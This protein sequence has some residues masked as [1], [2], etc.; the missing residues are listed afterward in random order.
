MTILLLTQRHYNRTCMSPADDC[1]AKCD[2][3]HQQQACLSITSPAKLQRSAVCSGRAVLSAHQGLGQEHLQQ[4]LDSRAEQAPQRFRTEMDCAMRMVMTAPIAAD[5]TATNIAV[6]A[7]A[8]GGPRPAQLGHE[9]HSKAFEPSKY[10]VVVSVVV[11]SSTS[12]ADCADSAADGAAVG[13]CAG[14]SRVAEALCE[15]LPAQFPTTTAAKRAL[16]RGRVS[17]N[18]RLAE[19]HMCACV[20]T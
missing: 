8:N 18:G 11:P 5:C 9:A 16:R 2:M 13:G 15:L 7:P 1:R 12:S 20:T 3:L 6:T 4:H 19:T 14:G 10:A 17:L